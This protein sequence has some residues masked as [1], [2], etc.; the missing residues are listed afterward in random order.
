MPLA[1]VTGGGAGL[2]AAI[3]RAAS[4]H[5]YDVAI[6]DRDITA[7][8]AL[9]DEIDGLMVF[10]G[11]VTSEP[12]I[13]AAL[14]ALEAAPDLVVNNAGIIAFNPLV[15]VSA[16]DFARVINVDLVGAFLVARAAAKRMLPRGSGAIVNI[17]SIGG[18]QPSLGTNAYAAAKSGLASLT[19]LMALE[20]GPQGLRVNAVAPGMIDGGMSSGI[21]ADPDA[22]ARRA[23]AV[24][25]RRLG[26]E[27]DIAEAV[28]FLASPEAAYIQGHQLVVDGAV[29]HAA[30][31]MI[32]RR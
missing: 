17:T 3:A 14:D 8:K 4:A 13:E 29:T 21:Y 16:E 23:G 19:E 30:L 18:I 15:D 20:W 26:T 22:R 32:P 25:A 28:M 27:A 7:A 31:A 24:P 10:E 2:G 12:S 5:G 9:S 1:F 11:D 6:F